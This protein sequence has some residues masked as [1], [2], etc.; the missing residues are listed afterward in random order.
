MGTAA[1]IC[2]LPADTRIRIGGVGGVPGVSFYTIQA[3]DFDVNANH[4]LTDTVSLIWQDTCSSGTNNCPEG[5]QI[6]GAGSSTLVVPL[7]S[8]T[9][10]DIHNAAHRW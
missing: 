7:T 9:V 2:T 5:D 4:R 1:A 8:T 3:A 6:G 10:T